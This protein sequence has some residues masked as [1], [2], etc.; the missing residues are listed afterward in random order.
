MSNS[1]AKG[2]LEIGAAIVVP[3][4]NSSQKTI[5]DIPPIFN[6]KWEIEFDGNARDS[7]VFRRYINGKISEGYAP[8]GIERATVSAVC[9]IQGLQ[10]APPV[11]SL[12]KLIV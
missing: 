7:F 1:D 5:E 3:D 12:D 2:D 11:R 9:I 8:I 10:P 4:S 6:E